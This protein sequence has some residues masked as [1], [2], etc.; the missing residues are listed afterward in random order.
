M[1]GNPAEPG[2]ELL[3][4]LRNIDD[5]QAA[6]KRLEQVPAPVY[7]ERATVYSY[8]SGTQCVIQ[9]PSG[10][11]RNA[12]FLTGYIPV[13]GHAVEVFNMPGRVFILKPSQ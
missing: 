6:V 12:A 1:A 8:T 4:I 7:V 3:K 13:A 5:L 2:Y 11:L 10:T 9:Y